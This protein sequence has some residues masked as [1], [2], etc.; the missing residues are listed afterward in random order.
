MRKS[1]AE[2]PKEVQ[3]FVYRGKT[4]VEWDELA[5]NSKG[6]EWMDYEANLTYG[7]AFAKTFL[8]IDPI[9]T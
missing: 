9:S 3:E 5:V 7:I 8:N 2:E 1:L 4:L 6:I